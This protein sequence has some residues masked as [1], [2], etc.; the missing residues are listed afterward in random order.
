MQLPTKLISGQFLVTAF[1]PAT[2][3]ITYIPKNTPG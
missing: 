1:N 2:D 3:N